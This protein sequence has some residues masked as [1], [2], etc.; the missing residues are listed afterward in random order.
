M[1]QFSLLVKLRTYISPICT[2]MFLI[3]VRQII[4]Q[5]N[6]QPCEVRD[7]TLHGT[8]EPASLGVTQMGQESPRYT[9]GSKGTHGLSV[10]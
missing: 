9:P 5:L 7:P 6:Q 8:R 10:W 3:R 4:W 1:L 2:F